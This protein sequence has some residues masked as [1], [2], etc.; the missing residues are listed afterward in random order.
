M[1]LSLNLISTFS[2]EPCFLF[3][4]TFAFVGGGGLRETGGGTG[5]R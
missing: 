3:S 1:K 2:G 4:F 5:N